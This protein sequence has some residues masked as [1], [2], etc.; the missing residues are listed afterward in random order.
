MSANK[1]IMAPKSRFNVEL[2]LSKALDEDQ[3]EELREGLRNIKGFEFQMRI[4][5]SEIELIR[6]DQKEGT[7]SVAFDK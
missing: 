4:I 7:R 1:N 5:Y 2:R 3:I 6:D